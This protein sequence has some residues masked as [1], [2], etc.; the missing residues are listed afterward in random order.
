MAACSRNTC[1]RL[2]DYSAAMTAEASLWAEDGTLHAKGIGT[3]VKSA[4]LLS[5]ISNYADPFGPENESALE[6]PDKPAW[7]E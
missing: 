4:T 7:V 6:E 1:A 3:F 5:S 2:K